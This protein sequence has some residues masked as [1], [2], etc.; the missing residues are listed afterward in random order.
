MGGEYDLDELKELMKPIIVGSG[1]PKMNP[2]LE[3]LF[4]D[5]IA[6]AN[7]KARIEIAKHSNHTLF[8]KSWTDG[9]IGDKNLGWI[10]RRQLLLCLQEQQFSNKELGTEKK[11]QSIVNTLDCFELTLDAIKFWNLKYDFPQLYSHRRGEHTFLFTDKSQKLNCWK[12]LIFVARTYQ[13]QQLLKKKKTDKIKPSL[14]RKIKAYLSIMNDHV[15]PNNSELNR[16]LTKKAE[17]FQEK[18]LLEAKT[19]KRK[20]KTNTK[21]IK[22]VAAKPKKGSAKLAGPKTTGLSHEDES[23]V[24]SSSRSPITTKQVSGVMKSTRRD[25]QKSKKPPNR[26]S[27]AA[28]TKTSSSKKAPPRSR[29]VAATVASTKKRKSGTIVMNTTFS[30]RNFGRGGKK[31]R[32]GNDDDARPTAPAPAPRRVSDLETVPAPTIA[33]PT[34]RRRKCKNVT[35]GTCSEREKVLVTSFA[36]IE[37]TV[38]QMNKMMNF[39]GTTLNNMDGWK[40]EI[41]ENIVERKKGKAAT[42][43]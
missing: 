24:A 42:R 39:F 1:P 31:R 6:D 29:K 9:I 35:G 32:R 33:S 34:V 8:E 13:T 37:Q 4:V 40:Q 19:T 21:T 41:R 14:M 22:K 2:K 27:T 12:C 20:T 36:M 43:I 28:K 11:I 26:K 25:T 23:N 18:K 30:D 38:S 15:R 16:L 5:D 7:V 10:P 3:E 17:K